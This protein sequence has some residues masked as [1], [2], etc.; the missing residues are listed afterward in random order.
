[1]KNP[2]F[3]RNLWLAFSQHRLIAMP[4][5]LALLFLVIIM[6]N[7]LN[8][9]KDLHSA[10]TT[11]FIFIVWLWGL[12]NANASIVDELRDHT[13]DQQRMSALQPW[14]MTWGKLFGATAFNWYGGLIC[15]VVALFTGFSYEEPDT[16]MNLLTLV[17]TAVLLH[18]STIAL[19]LHSSHIESRIIQRGGIGWLVLF[20]LFTAISSSHQVWSGYLISWWGMQIPHNLFL[21][22]SS[23]LFA[24]CAVF[25]AWRAMCNALQVHTLPWAWPS[26]AV[27]LGV[28]LAGFAS[29]YSASQSYLLFMTVLVVSVIMSYAALFTE[30]SGLV[31]LRRLKLLHGKEDW[32]GLFEQLPLWP[33]TFALAFIFALLA[34]VSATESQLSGHASLIFG[35]APLGIALMLLRDACI[36]LF[37][38]F[39]KNNKRAVGA[40][41]FYLVLINMLLP[42]LARVA[43]MEPLSYFFLPIGNDNPWQGVLIMLVHSAIAISL[44]GWRLRNEEN[45]AQ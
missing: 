44:L 6:G 14:D 8:P 22:F 29:N 37:F 2:E 10:A 3:K 35:M 18:A 21:F 11:L 26:F 23:A 30:P 15:L 36:F 40:T 16:V 20:I 17:T 7:T 5:M 4:A 42:L 32:L 9:A 39:S 1:M 28:Y 43:N 19:N 12:R 27:V 13:W 38:N 25:A 24:A 33:T 31:V 34:S 41:M 45:N